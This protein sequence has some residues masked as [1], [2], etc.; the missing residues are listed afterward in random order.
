MKVTRPRLDAEVLRRLDVRGRLQ[1][2]RSKRA[3]SQRVIARALL[4]IMEARIREPAN[5]AHWGP[6]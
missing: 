5:D 2:T 3:R 4:L 6:R 1:F